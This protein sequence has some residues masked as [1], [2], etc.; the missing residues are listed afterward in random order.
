VF[1]LNGRVPIEH[2]T[3][4][5]VNI[6]EYVD[7]SFYD[8][9]HFVE[10][11]RLKAPAIG[12][13]L[14]IATNHGGAMTYWILKANGQVL[15]RSTVSR[16]SNLE[17]QTTEV[18]DSMAEFTKSVEARLKDAN[19]VIDIGAKTEPE[20]WSLVSYKNDEDWIAEF[21]AVVADEIV[22]EEEGTYDIGT[23]TYVNMEITLPRN[24]DGSPMV[25]RV[26][27][28]AKND[29]GKPIG[30]AHSN[31][32]LDPRAYE[33]ELAGGNFETLRANVIAENL[34]AYLDDDGQRFQLLDE[35]TDH[36]MEDDAYRRDNAYISDHNGK[37]H[38]RKSY[39][40][41]FLLVVWKDGSTNWVKLKDIA[42][43]NPIETA[44]YALNNK[45][46]QE[47]AVFSWWSTFILRKRDRI[48]SKVKS[49]YW[50]RTHKYGIEILKSMESA[51]RIDAANGNTLWQDAVQEEMAKINPALD[52]IYG[53]V[54]DYVRYQRITGHLIFDIKHSEGFRRKARYVAGGHQTDSPASITYS[55][56]VA[57]DSVRT[58]VMIAALNGLDLNSCDIKN[59]YLTADCRE[60]ILIKAGPEFGPERQGT[61]HKVRKALYGLKSSGAVL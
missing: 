15:A 21:N 40:G 60:K 43:S 18:K 26:T 39:R 58:I 44:E 50:G 16:V 34:F 24:I 5:S 32:L 49:K 47:P 52:S 20:D 9:A 41:W 4:E 19:F 33:V 61:W 45:L 53:N 56:V 2:V 31:P 38:L 37:K 30:T 25:G 10:D 6:S 1:S 8:W 51:K 23:D 55:S 22:P 57:R 48:I 27:K 42:N 17:Q 46:N 36:W 14:G 35:I 54:D 59:A 11:E 7:M 3:G 28:R 12:R 13:W 29:D